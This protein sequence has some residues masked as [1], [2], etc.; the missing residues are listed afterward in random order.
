[1]SGEYKF[2][3][4]ASPKPMLN[5]FPRILICSLVLFIYTNRISGQTINEFKEIWVNESREY[6]LNNQIPLP[7]LQSGFHHFS[8]VENEQFTE[9]LE[10]KWDL[11]Q[12]LTARPVPKSK[13]FETQP[14]FIYEEASYHNPHILPYFLAENVPDESASINPP[15]IRKPEYTSSGLLK[16]N[17]KF[18]GNNLTVSCDRLLSLPVSQL[19]GK[20]IALEFWKKFLIGNSQ[21]LISQLLIIRDRLGLNDWGYFLLVKTVSKELYLNDETGSTLL[22]WALMLHSGF[23]VKIG[24][25][26]LGTSLLYKT[27]DKIYGTPFVKI[28]NSEFY[29]DRPIASFPIHTYL[30]PHPGALGSIGLSI[31]KALNFQGAVETKKIDFFWNKKQYEFNIRYN[32][33]VISYLEDYPQTEPELFF[34]SPFTYFTLESLRKQMK[35]ILS[36]MKMEEAAAFLQQFVQ[37]SFTYCP[38]NDLYGF[39]RFMFPE[40]ILLKEES[41]DKGKS[42]L[43]AWL[44][45]NLLNQ[46]AI[47]VEFPGFYSVA[48]SLDQPMDG[49]NF[50]LDGRNYTFA[51]PTF[52]DAPLGLIMSELFSL[53]PLL[54][55][56]VT[57]AHELNEEQKIWKL[58][59]TFGAKRSGSGKDFVRGENGNAYITGY[60]NEKNISYASPSPTPFLAKFNVQNSLEWMVKFRSEGSAFGL[61]LKQL[62]SNEL[63]L[64]GTF[65]G[66]LECNGK[67]IQTAPSDPDLFFVQ[68]NKMGEIGWMTK[69]GF[70]ELEEDTKLFYVVKFTRSGEIQSVHLSNEDERS[71]TTGFQLSSNEGL[72]YIASRHQTT[73]LDKTGEEFAV[74]PILAYRKYFNRLKQLGTEET[75]AS[76]AAVLKSVFHPG[77]QLSGSDLYSLRRVKAI[78]EISSTSSM[79]EMLQN[80]R[81]IKNNFGIIEI[82]TANGVP[83]KISPFVI[84]NRSHLKIIPLDNND[85]KINVIDGFGFETGIQREKINSMIIELTTGNLILDIG[86]E[87]QIITRSLKHQVI[88]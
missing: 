61:E 60:I 24:Y 46:R 67:V 23:D 14:Q 10:D 44:I 69:S 80:L 42:L 75:I 2:F 47:L 19:P 87:H 31:R 53:K 83:L 76:L 34:S 30:S 54:H 70:D 17:I 56:L 66:K 81:L 5:L 21:H 32:P 58:A 27:K 65:R 50:Q 29:V 8:R 26:Q 43:Y 59:Q 6:L 84:S 57:N 36:G 12:V 7:Y 85:L 15:R 55:P 73:G 3:G 52:N 20:E 77:S 11:I 72:C 39:D 78:P 86:S 71:G 9:I 28:D 48:I 41:N 33:M 16:I 88:K 49:D 22:G 13:K 62:D 45:S 51:D 37:K 4:Q 64:A 40:E 68:F 1:L 38:Y 35:P 82:T 79:T 74:K 18:Y 63:Y 25:N